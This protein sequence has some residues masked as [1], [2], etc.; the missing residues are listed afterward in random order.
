MRKYMIGYGVWNKRHMIGWL[1]EGVG[2]YAR[3]ARQL[4]FVF[5]SCEDESERMFDMLSEQIIGNVAR[6]RH[7]EVSKG[8]SGETLHETGLHNA[9]LEHFIK[10]TDCDVLIVPQDDQ[11]I[12]GP[13]ILRMEGLLDCFGGR[14]GMVG[15]RDGY[16]RG[17]SKITGSEWSES[18][19]K[20]R[21][22]PGVWA[23]RS[24]LNSGPLIYVRTVVEKVGRI[25]PAYEHW[26]AW[27]DY[28]MRCKHEHGLTNVVVGTEIRHLKFGKVPST[29]YY[30][31]GSLKHDHDL[32]QRKWGDKAW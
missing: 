10:E 2:T 15:G 21:L 20:D 23:E 1:L 12:C 26:Y 29:T 11:R 30:T 24:F 25:D 14:V 8:S 6:S 27:D 32:F 3:E 17:L 4:R 9:L 5:D 13:I 31:D 28:C 19:L 18:T 7:I 22:R 16:E